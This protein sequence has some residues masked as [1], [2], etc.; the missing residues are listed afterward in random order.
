MPGNTSIATISGTPSTSGPVNFTV[1]VKDSAGGSG[2]QTFTGSIIPGPVIL[3][4]SL[5]TPNEVGALFNLTPCTVSSGTGTPPYTWSIVAGALPNVVSLNST[6]GTISGTPNPSAIGP[7]NYTLR[8]VD[9]ASVPQSANQSFTGTIVDKPAISCAPFGTPEVGEAYSVTCNTTGGVPPFTWSVAPGGSL[10]PT[11]SV[12]TGTGTVN[13]TL[14][15]AGPFSFKL[16]LTDSALSTATTAQSAAIAGTVVNGPKFTCSTSSTLAVNVLYSLSCTA[17]GGTNSYSWSSTG[18]PSWLTLTPAGANATI[19]GTPQAANTGAFSFTLRVTDT[20]V[21][22]AISF[23]DV[24]GGN[25]AAAPSVTCSLTTGPSEQNDPYSTNCSVSGGT[26][27][28]SWAITP[29]GA[30]PNGLT[31]SPTSGPSTTVSGPPSGT[32]PYNYSV[33]VTDSASTPQKAGVT[34]TGTIAAALALS[35]TVSA[36]PTSVG[37]TYLN[38]CT[39]T[40]GVGPYFWNI[41]NGTL[42][43]GLTA[44]VNGATFTIQGQPTAQGNF[45]Y[46]VLLTDS[47]APPVSLNKDYSGTIFNPPSVTCSTSKGPQQVGVPYFASCSVAG[48]TPP[49]TWSI[50]PGT[51]PGGISLNPTTGNITSVAGTPTT[52]GTYSYTVRVT[53]SA[54]D[55]SGAPAHQTATAPPFTGIVLAAITINCTPTL[56][57]TEVG[58][59]YLSTCTVGGGTAPYTWSVSSG[60]IPSGL[61]LVSSSN[62]TQASVGSAAFGLPGKPTAALSYQYKIK[63]QDGLQQFAEQAFGG[64]VAGPPTFACSPAAGPVEDN[65]NYRTVCTAS[66]GT[67]TGTGYTWTITP[68]VATP[69]LS[70]LNAG[71]LGNANQAVTTQGTAITIQGTPPASGSGLP[72]GNAFNFTIAMQDAAVDYTGAPAVQRATPLVLS[73]TTAPAPRISCSDSSPANPGGP[74]AQ[75]V[76]YQAVCIASAGIGPYSWSIVGALPAGLSLSQSGPGNNTATISGAPTTFGPFNYTVAFVDSNGISPVGGINGNPA[77]NIFAGNTAPLPTL[78]CDPALPPLQAGVPYSATCTVTGGTPPYNWQLLGQP[79]LPNGLVLTPDS[80]QHSTA[81]ITGQLTGISGSVRYQIKVTDSAIGI[82]RIVP[83]SLTQGSSSQPQSAS[84]FYTALVKDALQITC[85]NTGGPIEVGVAYQTKCT[86]TGGTPPYAFGLQGGTPSGLMLTQDS[87]TATLSGTP[88]QKGSYEYRIQ[89]TDQAQ[90]PCSSG[91]TSS[92]VSLCSTPQTVTSPNFI[93][94][95][96]AAPSVLCDPSPGPFELGVAYSVNC[97]ALDGTPPYTWSVAPGGALP[98]GL[99]LSPSGNRVTVSGKPTSNGPYSFAVRVTDSLN[100]SG[101]GSTFANTIAPVLKVTATHSGDFA[102]KGNG[103]V[104]LIVNNISSDIII[105]A[106]TVGLQLPTGLTAISAT[107]D[108]SWTCTQTGQS[109]NC[110]RS[111]NAPLGAQGAYPPIN[112]AVS[113]GDPAC[114]AIMVSQASVQLDQVQQNVGTDSLFPTGCLTITKQHQGSFPAGGSGSYSLIVSNASGVTVGAPVGGLI[115]VTDLLSPRFT[116]DSNGAAGDGWTCKAA[117]SDADPRWLVTCSRSDSLAAAGKFPPITVNVNV[118]AGACGLQTDPAVVQVGAVVEASS[119]DPTSISG[120]GCLAV[121][122]SYAV[123]PPPTDNKPLAP[124]S[125]SGTYTLKIS[126]IGEAPVTDTI[127]VTVALPNNF[128][129]VQAGDSTWTCDTTGPVTCTHTDALAGGASLILPVSVTAS[130]DCGVSNAEVTITLNGVTQS[131]TTIP[132]VVSGVT[133]LSASRTPLNTLAAGG[134]GSYS[135]IV[136][137]PGNA[138]RNN[139]QVDMKEALPAGLKPVSIA[140]AGWTCDAISGQN[141]ACHRSDSLDAGASYPP[142]TVT[143][144]ATTPACPGFTG[145]TYL[146]VNGN[147]ESAAIDTVLMTGCM[148]VAK[149]HSADYPIGGS[150]SYMLSVTYLGD[151]ALAGQVTVVDKLPLGLAPDPNGFRAPDGSPTDWNCAVGDDKQTVTCTRPATGT[152]QPIVVGVNVTVDACGADPSRAQV[153]LDGL[154]QASSNPDA[155]TVAG[156]CPAGKLKITSNTSTPTFSP[157][158]Q[159]HYIISVTNPG[160]APVQ[161]VVVVQDRFA[162]GLTPI[163]AQGDGWN[164][165]LSAGQTITCQRSDTLGPQQHYSNLLVDVNV[166]T[167]ACPSSQDSLTLTLGGKTQDRQTNQVNLRGCLTISPPSL[168]FLP[169]TVGDSA[170]QTVTLTATDRLP[171]SV[172]ITQLPAASVYSISSSS[173]PT[174][175]PGQSCTVLLSQGQGL[176]VDV[177]YKPQCIGTQSDTLTYTTEVNQ[178]TVGLQGAAQLKSFSI[179]RL[180]DGADLASIGSLPPNTSSDLGLSVTPGSCVG[181]TQQVTGSLV[182]EKFVRPDDPQPITYDETVSRCPPGSAGCSGTLQTGTVAGDI[183]LFAKFL[184]QN[185]NDVGYPGGAQAT[186]VRVSVPALAPVIN[187]LI[188]GTVSG[189]SFQLSVTGY[190][191]P[192]KNTQACFKFASAPGTVLNT[193]ALNN[194][195]A[196]DDIAIWY[197]RTSSVPTGSQFTT[198][199]TFSFAGDVNAIGSVDGWLRNDLGD[200]DHFCMDFKSGS[201]RAGACQ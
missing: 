18:L 56:G 84:F 168:N 197:E 146:N 127:G 108:G 121:S 3:C 143:L 53:D 199:V 131:T 96:Q 116:M 46:R 128:S 51:L 90:S 39:A 181:P 138:A 151:N 134:P 1:Q 26:P 65:L 63:V 157:N 19:S 109:V 40:N 170:K 81:T 122:G 152:Y 72:A 114:G 9:S 92:G 149:S 54:T 93:G 185:R 173:C 57:P 50:S 76:L 160:D 82:S 4:S 52:P 79:T 107:S 198:A 118:A 94:T 201:T 135:V 64:N 115:T 111:D 23:S 86:V 55:S 32:G 88:L 60:A 130:V 35:C 31:L 98:S 110:K 113:V 129:A 10:P 125:V 145:T 21:P 15:T 14:T 184:D 106:T 139:I 161:D 22:N 29:P 162:P 182:F 37:V 153:Q 174:L 45:S 70:L 83:G 195:Y 11:L 140:G 100:S 189:S 74:P 87:T 62:T 42:P 142:V 48:G 137:N 123:A 147:A 164:C 155:I 44:T 126:N 33:Q 25:V 85:A 7:V 196:K 105:G 95:V 124:V 41:V 49:Y 38:T 30:L 179:V 102:L 163:N 166:D 103:V 120:T 183:Y 193:N 190:S 5:A 112:V 66:G 167:R 78:T 180:Q 175:A 6:T 176:P 67:P 133:C 141:I 101:V 80:N 71:V 69:W 192:R 27:P 12:N 165:D 186:E 2:T 34:F 24:L 187:N 58:V 91:G 117:Q 68:A 75:A 47:A 13:G 188:K 61:S 158:G 36:G 200:S 169:L 136:S 159:G 17:T 16:Q 177:V 144:S 119:K 148:S 97:L 194:C 59:N 28:F 156:T 43:A 8:V 89:V 99:S 104:S 172:K 171:L 154:L 178:G 150:S 77:N 20:A 73:G 191:T 132:T